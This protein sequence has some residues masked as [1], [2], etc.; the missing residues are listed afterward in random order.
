[1]RL[2]HNFI[3]CLFFLRAGITGG[4]VLEEGYEETFA[5][6]ATTTASSIES[7]LASAASSSTM[8][9]TGMAFSEAHVDEF[10]AAAQAQK[11]LHIQ[12]LSLGGCQIGDGG[13]VRICSALASQHL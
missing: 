10:V 3:T 13:I 9:L 6:T 4:A 5:A 2:Y 8:D 1:L 11:L 7:A 12:E